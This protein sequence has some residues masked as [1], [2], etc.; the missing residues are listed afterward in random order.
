MSEQTTNINRGEVVK[1]M[2]YMIVVI[3]AVAGLALIAANAITSDADAKVTQQ[4]IW[5]V[6]AEDAYG[7]ASTRVRH[8]GAGTYAVRYV[9]TSDEGDP[10]NFG[11]R[12]CNFNGKFIKAWRVGDYEGTYRVTIPS[13][14]YSL[15]VYALDVSYTISVKKVP[16]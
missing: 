5:K 8:L 1:R 7:V 16:R 10:C 2:L 11:I 12:L 3:L 9:A 15:V 6:A 4:Y 13:G 14:D